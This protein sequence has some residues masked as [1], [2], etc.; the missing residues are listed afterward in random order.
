MSRK[1]DI[2]IAKYDEIINLPRHISKKRSNMP[3]ENRAAQFAPFAAVVGHEAA[4]KES[5]RLTDY[6]R[7]LDET[8]KGAINDLLREIDAS[9][10][11]TPV[12][13]LYFFPDIEKA[14]GEYI[15]KVGLVSKVDQ[16]SRSVHMS[17]GTIIA[18]EEIFQI[19]WVG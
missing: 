9:L 4:V 14:G 13:I 17:D 15:K 3:V 2:D 18:I 16:Y 7:E 10:P 1:R 6:R 12:E 8:Q 19:K 5:A 11:T